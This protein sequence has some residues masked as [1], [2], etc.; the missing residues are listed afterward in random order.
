IAQRVKA[1]EG[2]AGL[3]AKPVRLDALMVDAGDSAARQ[4]ADSQARTC[5]ARGIHYQLHTFPA[6]AGVDDT[7]GR[8]LLRDTPP[9]AAAIMVDV[10]LPKGVDP[11]KIQRLIAPEKDVEG[12]NPVNIGNV[13]YGQSSLVPCTALAVLRMVESTKLAIR[14]LRAVVVGAGDVV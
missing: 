1:V 8:T 10:P 6:G 9:E 13:V 2:R 3:F 14:G 4:Y 5:A 12:V 11:H 7:A